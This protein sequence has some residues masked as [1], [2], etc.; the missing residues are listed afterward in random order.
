M[1][2]WEYASPS[3]EEGRAPQTNP[4]LSFSESLLEEEPISVAMGVDEEEG[5]ISDPG[6]EIVEKSD[7]RLQ[8]Q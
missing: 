6:T 4:V 3:A 1:G 5:A 7:D 2:L 8:V